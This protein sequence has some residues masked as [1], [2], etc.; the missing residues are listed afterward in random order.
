VAFRDTYQGVPREGGF[1]NISPYAGVSW[2]VDKD[3]ALEFNLMF[4]RYDAI[5]YHHYAGTGTYYPGTL[6]TG[7]GRMNDPS[8]PWPKDTLDKHNRMVPHLEI[9]Y[10]F[11]F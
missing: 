10:V 1:S 5:E 11:H 6:G 2:N 3:S 8:V 7:Q 4:L 9:A